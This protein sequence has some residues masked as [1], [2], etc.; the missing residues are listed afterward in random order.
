MTPNQFDELKQVVRDG[1]SQVGKRLS[2]LERF[3]WS[4]SATVATLIVL[5]QTGLIEIGGGK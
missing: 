4:I 2:I 5:L 1:F 3:M